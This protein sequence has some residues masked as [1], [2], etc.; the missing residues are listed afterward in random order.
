MSQLCLQDMSK[1][2]TQSAI[3]NISSSAAIGPGRGP[4]KNGEEYG[5]S[6]LY[7]AEKAFLERFTQGLAAEVYKNNV[8][9]TCV[10]PSQIVPTP[11]VVYHKLLHG[12][13]M[14]SEM[15]MARSILLLC[16]ESLD[17]ITGRVC[18]SQEILKEFGKKLWKEDSNIPGGIGIDVPGSGYS[19]I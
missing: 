18:Y 17:R 3:C 8:S 2:N 11:G 7:G 4:Y 19:K 9:V 15:T 13:P 10:S 16:T 6:V 14:E 1:T 5:N 12:Q